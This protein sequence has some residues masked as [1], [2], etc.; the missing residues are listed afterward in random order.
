MFETDLL[1]EV[2]QLHASA[3]RIAAAIDTDVSGAVADVLLDELLAAGRQVDLASCR[4]VERVDRSGQFSVDGAA[5]STAFVGRKVNE[6]GEWAAKRVAAGRALADRLPMSAKGWEAGRLGLE[7]ASVIDHATRRIEDPELVAEVDRI[8]SEAAA[9]GLDPTDLSRLAETVRAQTMP[10]QAA[11]KAKR[12]H[13]DQSLHAST[14]L[15]GMVHVSGLLDPEAGAAFKRALGSFTPKAP[16]PDEKLADPSYLQPVAFRRALG[17]SQMARHAIAHAEGCNCEGATRDAM[18]IGVGLDVLTKGV[19]VGTVAGGPTLGAGTLRRLA[20]D[21]EIIPAVLGTDSEILDLGR[22][23]RIANAAL[24]A[25]VIARDGGCIFPGCRRPPSWCEC[26]HRHHWVDGGL[27]S[28]ENLDLVCLHHHH[29]LHEGGWRLT[30]DNNRER[31]PWFHPPNGGRAL[32]GQRCPLI[33]M[34]RRT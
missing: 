25:A 14:T 28:L 1:A 26:H 20:C 24:R 8:L 16:T 33:P 4:T 23:A 10:E 18:I 17:L 2:T 30:V 3:A 29:L 9:N 21:A 22:R 6:R 15:D 12:Q 27:T 5:S 19:G 13:R 31:T 11:D 32:K 7:H 34:P